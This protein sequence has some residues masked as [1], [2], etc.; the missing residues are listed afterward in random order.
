MSHVIAVT[1]ATG[2][3]GGGLVRAILAQPDAGFTVRAIT[4][5]PGSPAAVAVAEAGAE[6]VRADLDDRPSLVAAFAGAH[7][8]FCVTNF[9]EHFDPEL[10]QTQAANL[11]AAVAEAGV[12]HAIW[13]T[14]EDV[15]D[16]VPLADPRMPTLMGRYKV[17]HFDAKGASDQLFRAAGVPTTLLRTCFYWDNMISFGMGPQPGADGVLELTLPLGD[18]PLAGIAAADIGACAFGLFA[19]GPPAG[20]PTVG[21]AG[22]HPTGEQ[23]AAGL[24]QALGRPVR[25]R[26]IA[27]QHYRALPIPAADELA[28]MFQFNTQFAEVYCGVRDVEHTRTLHPGL[29]GFDAWATARAA[30][31]AGALAGAAA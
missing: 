31:L 30:D 28:N 15:R 24:T 7:G 22:G 8:A 27:L 11:A 18:A 14:L 9:W 12:R 16:H 6:V 21:I 29:L 3:Q 19:A 5:D 2:A 4:R 1:G 20:C 23:M 25:Y 10:E 17:P 13:S 26:A